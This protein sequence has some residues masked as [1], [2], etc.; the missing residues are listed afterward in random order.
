MIRL[1]DVTKRFGDVAAVDGAHSASRAAR[2]SR[3]SGLPAAE[4]R[5]SCAWS[6]DSSA[7]MRA[8]SSRRALGS[9]RALGPAGGAPRRDGVP[10]LRALPPPDRRGQCRIRASAPARASARAGAARARG[11][12]RARRALP[13]RA[14]RRP[15]AA[16]RP[17]ARARACTRAR[18]PR[19]AVVERRS[20]AARVASRRGRGDHPPARRHGRPRDPR[21]RGGVLARRPHRADAR[22][23]GRAGGD[24]RG[25]LLRTC[26][27]LGGRVRRRGNVLT[28]RVVA[29]RV[30]TPIGAFPAN[31]VE[32]CEATQVLVRPELLELEPTLRAPPRSWPASSA[33][34]TSSTASCSTA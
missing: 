5:P 9:G 29:G 1:E 31:G 13:A 17:G 20:I 14:L 30:E 21:S 22:R 32:R 27:T 16:G 10:G 25:A 15:A 18:A 34:T 7:P 8:P 23:E 3:C 26:V 6:P 12:R 11:A 28:G 4:R 33:A 2:S 19:R 24:A